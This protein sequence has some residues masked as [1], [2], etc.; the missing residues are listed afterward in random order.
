LEAAVPPAGAPINASQEVPKQNADIE[1]ISDADA[2]MMGQDTFNSNNIMNLLNN[3][4]HPVLGANVDQG[5]GDY[6]SYGMSNL[7]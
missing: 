2:M 1:I 6:L 5:A 7:A 3:R 4:N